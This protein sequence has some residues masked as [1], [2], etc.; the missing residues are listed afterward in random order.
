MR[1]LMKKTPNCPFLLGA[2]ALSL[3][4]WFTA[5]QST[6]TRTAAE[7]RHLQGYWEG[8]G[9]EGNG[10]R[11]KCSLTITGNSLHCYRDSNYWFETTITLPA[12][13]NPQ[14]LHATIKDTSHRSHTG[15]VVVAIFKIEN[16]TL[17]LAASDHGETPKNFEDELDSLYV[18]R[19]VKPPKRNTEPP[20]TN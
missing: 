7:L 14:Q 12:G 11:R 19:K 3:T 15:Q 20:K 4:A 16:G 10:P 18:L 17:T 5:C 8:E 6:P 9:R 13:T 1:H 2:V